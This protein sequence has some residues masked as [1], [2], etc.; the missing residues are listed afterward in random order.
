[1]NRQI[2]RSE[3]AAVGMVMLVGMATFAGASSNPC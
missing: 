2:M 1:M 3:V